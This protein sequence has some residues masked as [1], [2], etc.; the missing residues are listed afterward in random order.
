MPEKKDRDMW[1]SFLEGKPESEWTAMPMSRAKSKKQSSRGMRA[2]ADEPPPQEYGDPIHALGQNNDEGEVEQVL[3]EDPADTLPTP[4][5]TPVALE[6]LE[7]MMQP[8][9]PGLAGPAHRKFKP[10]DPTTKLLKLIDEVS[11]FHGL[12]KL[13]NV[14]SSERP[15]IF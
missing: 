10:R 6:Y 8:S 1:W 9:V 12:I 4:A 14:S 3:R 15:S 5:V 7:E 13:T 2:W 11:L